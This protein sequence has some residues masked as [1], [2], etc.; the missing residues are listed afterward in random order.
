MSVC[1]N[2]GP[3]A[4]LRP[5]LFSVQNE[6]LPVPQYEPAGSGSNSRPFRSASTV[7]LWIVIGVPVMNR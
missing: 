1:W 7:V 2:E 6:L 3:R 4:P 5:P